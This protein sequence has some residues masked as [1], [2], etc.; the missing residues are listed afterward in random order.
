MRSLERPAPLVA[1]WEV[2][3]AGPAAFEARWTLDD[4][5]PFA[6]HY[7][8]QPL[9]PG[10]FLVEAL[11]QAAA[12][13]LGGAWR[14]EQMGSCRFQAPVVPGDTLT[15]RFT[16]ADDGD[17]KVVEAT[18]AT[19]ADAG[20]FRLKLAPATPTP[21]PA[22]SAAADLGSARRIDA[23]SIR[24]VLPHRF[25]VLL[26]DRATLARA[27]QRKPALVA[28]KAVTLAEPCYGSA[29]IEPTT[30]AYPATLVAESFCQACGV[31][32][33]ASAPAGEAPDPSKVPV[34]ARLVKLT[35]VGEALPGEVLEHRVTLAARTP[36]GAVFSGE[37]VAG[38]RLIMTAERVVAATAQR[39]A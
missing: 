11:F 12:L 15:A 2:S 24:R 21:G 36:G 35:F 38:G 37:T 31:L 30:F 1:G 10:N 26:L 7:P 22:A 32:K 33:A 23:A 39:P 16:V 17:G 28:Q 14:L 4:P 8:G 19:R 5:A 20:T 29:G 13:A 18:A 3:V 25:P 9:L 27:D 6:G 34:L